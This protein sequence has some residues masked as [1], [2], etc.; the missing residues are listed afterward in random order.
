M[1]TQVPGAAKKSLTIHICKINIIKAALGKG[2]CHSLEA[3]YSDL[4]ALDIR[5]L[6]IY[7]YKHFRNIF[8]GVTHDYGTRAAAAGAIQTPRL[9]RTFSTTNCYYNA[10]IIHRHLPD[11]LKQPHPCTLTTYKSR[12]FEWLNEIGREGTEQLMTSD[13]RH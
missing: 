1:T 6:I 7:I 3:V 2:R 11:I 8:Q 12:V 10:H 13:Y 4:Q 9:F 5:T